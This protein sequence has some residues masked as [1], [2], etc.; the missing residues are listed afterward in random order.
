MSGLVARFGW[1]HKRSQFDLF[2]LWW[3]VIEKFAQK[4]DH[5]DD[6]TDD[7]DD[8]DDD[9]ED[10]NEDGDSGGEREQDNRG[11]SDND[12]EEAASVDGAKMPVG[13]VS[14]QSTDNAENEWS[15]NISSESEDEDEDDAPAKGF[16]KP[17]VAHYAGCS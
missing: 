2:C 17:E 12:D 7:D 10:D 3:Q 1:D 6:H 13:K 11:N 9:N 15:V 14:Q 16:V 5:V 8:D 4:Q